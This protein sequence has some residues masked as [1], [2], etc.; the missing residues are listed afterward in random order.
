MAEKPKRPWTVLPHST[1]QKIDDNLWAVVNDVPGPR[2]VRIPRRMCIIKRTDGSLL[3]FHAIPLDDATLAEVRAWGKPA[4]LV[5][6]HDQHMIDAEAFREKL[7]LKLFGPKECIAKIQARGTT[8]GVLEDI[9]SDSS[10]DIVSVPGTKHGETALILRSGE[11]KHA[12]LLVSDVIHNT[13]RE[14][15]SFIFRLLGFTGGP[16][17]VPAFRLLFIKDRAVLKAALMRWAEIPNLKRLVPF[18]GTIVENDTSG[19]IRAVAAKL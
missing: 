11:D 15:T 17:V 4:Y 7:G 2:F 10:M 14:A 19:A 12:S 6:G 18:H 3:F 16:K 1:L 9:P 8:A 13:P 5:V